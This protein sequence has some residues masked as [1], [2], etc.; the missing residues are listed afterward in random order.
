MTTQTETERSVYGNEAL[1]IRKSNFPPDSTLSTGWLSQIPAAWV[2]YAQLMRLDRPNGLWYF[3]LPHLFGSLHAGT[4]LGIPTR[5]LLYTN[6]ILLV[7]TIIMRGATCTWNDTVDAPFDRLV[8]RT[9]NRPVARGAVSPTAAHI[10][11]AVQSIISLGILTLLPP[12][13]FVYAIPAIVGWMLY[14][15]AKRVTY[16]PQVVLGFPM[17]WGI[18]MGSVAMGAD[19]LQLASDAASASSPQHRYTLSTW[20]LYTANV[21]WTLFYEIIYSHQDAAHD[22]SAG[23][24]N[25]VL[26]YHGKTKPLLAKLAL[27]QVLLLASVG[28]LSQA[29]WVYWSAT[30]CGSAATLLVIL[31]NVK[32]DVPENCAWWFK[33]G[34]PG[35]TGTSMA[36][37]LLGEYILRMAKT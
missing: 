14:P 23:V 12:V 5:S 24:K 21:F 3:Y 25:I 20:A 7:G 31:M 34:C 13:S 16:Y 15:L 35:F 29:S 18:F 37:G 22:A 26:L 19:P 10:F 2:P 33:V 6:L 11:T 27:G 8:P 28:W 36:A 4:H 32:L 30:V 9:K 17:A 1:S